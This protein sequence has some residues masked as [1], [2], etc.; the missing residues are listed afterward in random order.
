MGMSVMEVLEVWVHMD[1]GLVNMLMAMCATNL[2][3]MGMG[4]MTILMVVYVV[5]AYGFMRM[6]VSMVLGNGKISPP[7]HNQEGH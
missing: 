5:V 2:I 7:Y 3:I 1:C 6:G 4:V